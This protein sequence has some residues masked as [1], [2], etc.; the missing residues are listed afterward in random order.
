LKACIS[1]RLVKRASGA[2]L[3]H[4]RWACISSVNFFTP[5]DQEGRGALS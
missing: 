5:S 4:W 1:I 2:R 3:I